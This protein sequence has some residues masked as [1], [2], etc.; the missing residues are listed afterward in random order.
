MDKQKIVII[1]SET[2]VRRL[3]KKA[4]GL[5]YIYFEAEGGKQVLGLIR[6][7]KPD[8]VLVDI[9]MSQTYDFTIPQ[10]IKNEETGRVIPVIILTGSINN[11][12]DSPTLHTGAD[13]YLDKPLDIGQLRRDIKN[14]L[15]G[16]WQRR[17]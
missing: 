17:N 13:G 8:L 16:N 10:S 15:A 5:D 9:L 12:G 11:F 4:L 2:S 3:I 14:Y 1:S 6:R 7:Q